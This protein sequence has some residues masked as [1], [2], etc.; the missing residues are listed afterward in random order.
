MYAIR[1]LLS[2]QVEFEFLNFWTTYLLTNYRNQ[3]HEY[4]LMHVQFVPGNET[5]QH[6]EARVF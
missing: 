6:V 1:S 5:E 2:E 3:T 4:S